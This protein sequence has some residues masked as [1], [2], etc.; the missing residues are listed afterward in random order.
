MEELNAQV[1][2]DRFLEDQDYIQRYL[3]FLKYKT[4]VFGTD[5]LMVTRLLSKHGL[6]QI[7]LKRSSSAHSQPHTLVELQ[8]ILSQIRSIKP[9]IE[10]KIQMA[11]KELE[12][13]PRTERLNTVD[14]RSE[15]GEIISALEDKLRDGSS[16]QDIERVKRELL[17]QLNSLG[18]EIRVD[19][20]YIPS[21]YD[22]ESFV[23]YAVQSAI[24]ILKKEKYS[25]LE[26]ILNK[27]EELELLSKLNDPNNQMSVFRQGFMLLMTMFDATIFDV[28]RIAIRKNFFKL[29]G[30][31]GKQDK[32]SLD[33]LSSFG[34]FKEF[35]DGIIETQLKK[36][37]LKDI[38]RILKDLDVK[39]V[40]Q[41]GE[42]V[43]PHI[44]EFVLRRNIHVHNRG[45]VD[46]KYL[47]KNQKGAPEFNLYNFTIG[48]F[49][50]IDDE[51]LLFA[52]R[53]CK[54]YVIKAAEWADSSS[55]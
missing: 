25:E 34:S 46:N 22:T 24:Y 48:D 32:I 33:S 6:L 36:K 44:M 26:Y 5:M 28:V 37:Y 1:I 43:F 15:L 16:E 2:R 47:E 18:E 54:T 17:Y 23:N 20:Y 9:T 3:D 40:D 55:N 7:D 35:Q 27:L 8:Q 4:A 38:L 41:N 49:A 12:N 52:N 30:F 50:K 39:C 10:A 11:E 31:F 29:I 21:V 19:Y 53:L 13:I 45:I 14:V 42:D 51:Y